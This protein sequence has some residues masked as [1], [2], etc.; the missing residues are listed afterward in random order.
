MGSS[1]GQETHFHSKNADWLVIVEGVVVGGGDGG[2]VAKSCPVTL[3]TPWTVAYQA[4]LFTGF[5]SQEYWSELPFPPPEDLPDPGTEPASPAL[6]AE[7]FTTEPPG[8]PQQYRQHPINTLL[9]KVNLS[10]HL[11]N[12]VPDFNLF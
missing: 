2:L 8:K 10:G 9:K 1:H 4:P 6:A 5:P 11:I 7:F 12:E 3:W